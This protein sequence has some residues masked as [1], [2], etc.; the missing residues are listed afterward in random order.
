M[1]RAK[2]KRNI[3]KIQRRRRKYL[4]DEARRKNNN[5]K[6]NSIRAISII[7][8]HVSTIGKTDEQLWEIWQELDKGGYIWQ[9]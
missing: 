3:A 8:K 6:K 7:Q 9:R 4:A 2:S 5:K 1:K